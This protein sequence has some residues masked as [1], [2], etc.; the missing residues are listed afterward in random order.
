MK[1]ENLIKKIIKKTRNEKNILNIDYET[2]QRILKTSNNAYLVDVRSSQEFNEDRLISSINI[3]LYEIEN[4]ANALLPD[5]SAPVILYCQSG[6][7][8]KKACKIL[9]K[10]GYTNLYNL[11]GGINNI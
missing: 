8:S 3:P 1:I 7:R 10:L 5:K 6:A 2:L 11:V 9:E 4:S